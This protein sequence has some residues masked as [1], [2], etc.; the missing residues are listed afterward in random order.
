MKSLLL[1]SVIAASVLGLSSVA[2]ADSCNG[3]GKRTCNSVF[4]DQFEAKV[5]NNT[6]HMQLIEDDTGAQWVV[7]P[8]D[9]AEAMMGMKLKDHKFTKVGM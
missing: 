3:G 2:F 4:G 7:V 6:M 9:E 1:G 8:V 5:G